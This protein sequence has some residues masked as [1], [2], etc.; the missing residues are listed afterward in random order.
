[1]LSRLLPTWGVDLVQ[2]YLPLCT[3]D[4]YTGIVFTKRRL[5]RKMDLVVLL[6]NAARDGED[7]YVKWYL[8]EMKS[9]II[10]PLSLPRGYFCT[11]GR[12]KE[13]YTDIPFLLDAEER[14]WKICPMAPLPCNPLCPDSFFIFSS[15]DMAFLF[16]IERNTPV[17][18][19]KEE[20]CL[21]RFPHADQL[22]IGF[23]SEIYFEIESF[24]I[25][26][27]SLSGEKKYVWREDLQSEVTAFFISVGLEEKCIDMLGRLTEGYIIM[28]IRMRH[29]LGIRDDRG[30]IRSM[31][32]SCENGLIPSGVLLS[33]IEDHNSEALNIV[34]SITDIPEK[35]IIQCLW[36]YGFSSE[37]ARTVTLSSV[38]MDSILDILL[39]RKRND[40]EKEKY[41]YSMGH[42]VSR[43]KNHFLGRIEIVKAVMDFITVERW[44]YPS[45]SKGWINKINEICQELFTE[46]FYQL[47]SGYCV[48]LLSSLAYLTNQR[49]VMDIISIYV[50]DQ[51]H[52]M[53]PYRCFFTLED[54]RREVR[55]WVNESSRISTI[56]WLTMLTPSCLKEIRGTRII[57][58]CITDC[59]ASLFNEDREKV[60]GSTDRL[61]DI[62]PIVREYDRMIKMES[63]KEGEKIGG[64]GKR[65]RDEGESP[66][67]RV[68]ADT[69]FRKADTRRRE[70]CLRKQV[71]SFRRED[72]GMKM[73]TSDES[74]QASPVSPQRD[75]TEK[76]DEASEKEKL[77]LG[78]SSEE[79]EEI[80][81]EKGDEDP[82]GRKT[83]EGG[84]SY[85]QMCAWSLEVLARL[86]KEREMS[87]S[88]DPDMKFVED[89][90]DYFGFFE[91]YH[92][93]FFLSCLHEALCIRDPNF[94]HK[95]ILDRI[96]KIVFIGA[97]VIHSGEEIDSK[98]SPVI[99]EQSKPSPWLYGSDTAPKLTP[100][101]GLSP[102]MSIWDDHRGRT[103]R[104]QHFPSLYKA[105]GS[106]GDPG[107][108]AMMG[109][110]N[111]AHPDRTF[112]L[113]DKRIP[114]TTKQDW[115]GRSVTSSLVATIATMPLTFLRSYGVNESF[116]H[117]CSHHIESGA[118]T[119]V[120]M[121]NLIQNN[122]S[123]ITKTVNGTLNTSSTYTPIAVSRFVKRMIGSRRQN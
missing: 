114:R 123:L 68:K 100:I 3:E 10:S 108:D 6:V 33:I 19:C 70:S 43:H 96:G 36:I 44:R 22:S 101:Q 46:E 40:E 79:K 111:G 18:L 63:S 106:G 95:G 86:K 34:R 117:F 83:D 56:L 51:Y 31:L 21:D 93:P 92:Q 49:N 54:I 9:L 115:T 85:L 66:R 24:P 78:K 99:P 65:S 97:S 20:I 39:M 42:S 67:K 61:G 84:Y 37:F 55:V 74:G 27:S 28:T 80:T 30:V 59:L 98:L 118:I 77:S 107:Y 119:Y 88:K 120:S 29:Y 109:I 102:P 121:W 75:N 122:P 26:A 15:I 71:S 14:A 41:P 60:S 53:L 104:A 105:A 90:L 11:T 73:K 48:P 57:D 103:F 38:N 58:E 1:M 64:R 45:L 32:L 62:I 23:H 110:W 81:S 35:V 13:V 69:C 72:E 112:T 76:R 50:S 94:Y 82:W 91:D 4:V 116:S 52:D 17:L 113:L 8:K 89:I 7:V 87:R 2:Q 12:D 5:W 16:S 25:R 47:G